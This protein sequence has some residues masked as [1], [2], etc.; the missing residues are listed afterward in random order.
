[1]ECTCSERLARSIVNQYGR[2]LRECEHDEHQ[3]INPDHADRLNSS[4]PWKQ[5][6]PI[7][8]SRQIKSMLEINFGRGC[9]GEM[10]T[11]LREKFRFF[12]V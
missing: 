1:M 10:L 3:R 7:E 6:E 12:R 9:G 5:R 8:Q 4:C 11:S 2:N